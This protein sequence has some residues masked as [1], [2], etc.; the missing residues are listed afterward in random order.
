MNSAMNSRLDELYGM[1]HISS[2]A[3][4]SIPQLARLLDHNRSIDTSKAYIY[5]FNAYIP[6]N[7]DIFTPVYFHHHNKGATCSFHCP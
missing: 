4:S 1:L 5:I 2:Q 6:S 3:V 7:A